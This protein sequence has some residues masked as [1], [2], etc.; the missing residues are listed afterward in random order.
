MSS[1]SGSTA[2]WR[3]SDRE[4][5]RLP[6]DGRNARILP[7]E[8]PFSIS[9]ACLFLIYRL[10][11]PA[12]SSARFV[13]P[14]G[15][16][17][18]DQPRLP[19]WKDPVGL[20]F[21]T[22]RLFRATRH[23][24][25]K[26]LRLN[27]L[28]SVPYEPSRLH[29]RRLGLA[30]ILAAL[31]FCTTCIGIDR[32]TRTEDAPSPLPVL[33]AK[34]KDLARYRDHIDTL[35]LGSSRMATQLDPTAVDAAAG[36]QGCSLHS[37]NL[38]VPRLNPIEFRYLIERTR[39]LHLPRLRWIFMDLPLN[40][41]IY[42][43][44]VS[45]DRVRFF[46]TPH[47]LIVSLRDLW[48]LPHSFVG[49]IWSS[50][51]LVAAF[52]Y[53]QTGTGRLASVLFPPAGDR[54]GAAELDYIDFSRRGFMPLALEK[55]T[56]VRRERREA[57]VSSRLPAFEHLLSM[58]RTEN[59]PISPLPKRRLDTVYELVEQARELAPSV[60]LVIMPSPLRGD[61]NE[62]RALAA[63]W[64]DRTQD[65]P[66]L[67]FNEPRTMPEF[68]SSLLWYDDAHLQEKPATSLSRKIGA[69]VCGAIRSAPG[70]IASDHI[71]EDNSIRVSTTIR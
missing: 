29:M 61:V 41:M 53:E 49:K 28:R 50:I 65:V 26:E 3:R 14:V 15:P 32:L 30:T 1:G 39:D 8:G 60:G 59:P 17:P 33:E 43:D 55:L 6:R 70:H 63:G 5:D 67:N 45:D 20:T 22:G 21:E 68:A 12:R 58:L 23:P 2:A 40:Q 35:F 62:D 69:A 24:N 47:N 4:N 16:A 37:Y 31:S 34:L 10:R 38:G 19:P 46:M 13:R 66:L 48:S 18:E 54:T 71:A 11:S 56:G 42:L 7:G 44:H 64:A 57:F 27:V 52:A 51:K 25:L 36:A 9:F